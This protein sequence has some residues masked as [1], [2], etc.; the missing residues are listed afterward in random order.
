M[1]IYIIL[2]WVVWNKKKNKFVFDQSGVGA[3]IPTI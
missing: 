2:L 3:I 1:P